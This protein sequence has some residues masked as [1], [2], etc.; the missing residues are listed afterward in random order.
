MIAGQ[1]A[2]I[3]TVVFLTGCPS[4]FPTTTPEP[5]VPTL[6]T[7]LDHLSGDVLNIPRGTQG[8][9]E[10]VRIG[11]ANTAVTE[12]TNYLEEKQ[13]GMA[14]ELQLFSKDRPTEYKT[15]HLG[16]I[17]EFDGHLFFVRE[18]PPPNLNPNDPPA[19]TGGGMVAILVISRESLPTGTP[20]P[21]TTPPLLDIPAI[22]GNPMELEAQKV[23]IGLT[24]GED[25]FVQLPAAGGLPPYT[26]TLWS[27]GNTP[28]SYKA[29]L[30]DGLELDPKGYLTG[31]LGTNPA[32]YFFALMLQDSGGSSVVTEHSLV[33]K[34]TATTEPSYGEGGPSFGGVLT[35]RSFEFSAGRHYGRLG[36]S[37][38][39][40]RGVA[41]FTSDQ[42][43]YM[44]PFVHGG[45]RPWN[46]IVSG[47]PEGL[48]YDPA[49]GIIY[50]TLDSAPRRTPIDV[51][52]YLKDAAGQVAY[53]ET[54]ASFQFRVDYVEV[55]G[56]GYSAT[57]G[58]GTLSASG[59]AG[60]TLSLSGY[61][62]IG[63]GSATVSLPAGSY[64]LTVT[65]PAG[66]VVYRGTV[67]IIAG[68]VT[69]ARISPW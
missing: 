55:A 16:D 46:F 64:T 3:L 34:G 38:W 18:L 1:V 26:W 48:T 27:T 10:T 39:L 49:T 7:S 36:Q 12:Y 35:I 24:V 13:Y 33:V 4:P 61:G 8:Q 60:N 11:L 62:I 40:S 28:S 5:S 30:P 52:S 17:F 69:T 43:V 6:D 31:T 2:L 58:S 15:V 25:V 67:T 21:E 53:P 56:G 45:N 29:G 54:G 65:S 23:T 19:A 51:R 14:A 32:N 9:Y 50:G 68:Q 47:L 41:D 37:G 63:V 20:A 59:G 42:F 66:V 44:V 22:Y 57:T